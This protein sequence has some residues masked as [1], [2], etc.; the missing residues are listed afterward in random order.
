MKKFYFIL[1]LSFISAHILAGGDGPQTVSVIKDGGAAVSYKINDQNWW[2][3]SLCN[4]NDAN[5]S[6]LNDRSK[7]PAEN[8]PNGA[9]DN[10]AGIDFGTPAS[11]LLDGGAMI[12]WGGE[13]TT[14][15]YTL[16]YRVYLENTT[17]P[18]WTEAFKVNTLVGQINADDRRYEVTGEAVNVMETA[19]VPGTYNFEV[20]L[21]VNGSDKTAQK[22][23][24]TVTTTAPFAKFTPSA[25]KGLAPM[26][27]IFTNE[28]LNV[29]SYSWD[30]G[31][32]SALSTEENPT[33][34][35]TGAGNYTVT[36]TASATGGGDSTYDVTINVL[37]GTPAEGEMLTGGTPLVQGAW[38]VAT[39][40]NS[41]N[42]TLTW[43]YDAGKP[44]GSVG[45]AVRVTQSTTSSASGLA[46]YQTVTLEAQHTYEFECLFRD[47][48]SDTQNFWMQVYI[49]KEQPLN[50]KDLD[51]ADPNGDSP[52]H[53]G[54]LSTWAPENHGDTYDPVGLNGLFSSRAVKGAAYTGDLCRFKAE[55][56]GEYYF[57]IRIGVWNHSLDVAF[58][59]LSLTDLGILNNVEI[60]A[61]NLSDNQI[62]TEGKR[63]VVASENQLNEVAIY[64]ASGML[65]E[66]AKPGSFNFISADLASGLYIVNVNG[67][68]YKIG[69]K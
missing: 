62:Y 22:S 24:F 48:N 30:F 59:D 37:D 44:A 39:L 2:G 63:I 18:A 57:I 68:S 38:N 25:T 33:H 42:P 27:V 23:T 49:T 28:S 58:S 5:Y 3:N 55:E 60:D 46:L 10:F 16:K 7:T 9:I 12:S 40:G 13:Y 54:E 35:F 34:T 67:I 52:S 61:V 8:G 11:L 51:V 4:G 47:L 43:D 45:S 53:I 20:L 26:T 66:T 56:D 1:M 31:D 65:I 64:N 32:G 17:A 19:V 6:N 29:D 15:T 50:T 36:L 69:V 14:S 21:T 41:L